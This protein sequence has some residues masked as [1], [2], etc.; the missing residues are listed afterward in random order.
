M[1]FKQ[2]SPWYCVRAPQTD[3]EVT[4][5]HFYQSQLVTAVKMLVPFPKLAKKLNFHDSYHC[6]HLKMYS[7][8]TSL[9][10]HRKRSFYSSGDTT[11]PLF[12]ELLIAPCCPKRSCHLLPP[13][14]QGLPKEWTKDP[15]WTKHCIPPSRA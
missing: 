5:H 15:D 7:L 3:W 13:G 4:Q 2:P 6:R 9:H 12:G 10:L 14:S 1:L 8:C 11:P